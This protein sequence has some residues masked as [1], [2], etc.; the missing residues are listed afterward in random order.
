MFSKANPAHMAL[1]EL[2]TC[3]DQQGL[4]LGTSLTSPSLNPH[5]KATFRS[6]T[7]CHVLSGETNNG[8]QASARHHHPRS[9][10][11]LRLNGSQLQL[12]HLRVGDNVID[13][14]V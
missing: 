9:K 3:I 6:L 5:Y 13:N 12:G 1:S 14:I 7:L 10:T 8:S 11:D 2:M 4:S